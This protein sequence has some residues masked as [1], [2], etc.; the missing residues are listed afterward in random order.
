MLEQI[1]KLTK[2]KERRPL[3]NCFFNF[4]LELYKE[5]EIVALYKYEPSRNEI[6]ISL[7][8]FKKK[9]VKSGN[10]NEQS[11]TFSNQQSEAISQIILKHSELKENVTH[12]GHH[13][14]AIIRV[15]TDKHISYFLVFEMQEADSKFNQAKSQIFH[16]IYCL[17]QIY[18]NHQEMISLNDKDALTGLYNRKAYDRYMTRFMN[19]SSLKKNSPKKAESSCL[20]I[21]DIDHFKRVN[22]TF[23]HL[24]GDEVLLHFSQQMQ[25]IFREDDLLFR[26]GGEEF[27]VIL[28]TV[29]IDAAVLALHRYRKHI[30]AYHFPQVGHIMVSIGVTK[31]KSEL[32]QT[33]IVDQADHALYYVKT[34]GRNNV[35]CYDTLV[36]QGHI[37]ALESKDTGDVELF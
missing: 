14:T 10:E 29:D 12:I 5:L 26:Y 4:M 37:Q 1:Y 19:I 3:I 13:D 17:S 32:L 18:A 27:I 15:D 20:A 16:D 9:L 6:P 28:N 7:E 31:I 24:Y 11:F 8:V 34:Q 25:V 36:K 23:G 30:E 35:A 2:I 21:L 22:D 33:E